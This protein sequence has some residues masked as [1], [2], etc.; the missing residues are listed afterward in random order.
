MYLQSPAD[1]DDDQRS[2]ERVSPQRVLARKLTD[3]I[4]KVRAWRHGVRTASWLSYSLS[5]RIT[6]DAVTC[7]LGVV[8]GPTR[9]HICLVIAFCPADMPYAPRIEWQQ[10][11]PMPAVETPSYH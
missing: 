4:G 7:V 11:P 10:R 9:E 1:M 8:Q 5:R 6:V 3:D 2:A